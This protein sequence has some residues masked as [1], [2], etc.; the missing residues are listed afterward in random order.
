MSVKC[1]SHCAGCQRHFGGVT[2]FDKHRK[3]FQC[4][5]PKGL[6]LVERTCNLMYEWEAT[7]TNHEQVAPGVWKA[8]IYMKL[9]FD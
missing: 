7:S 5:E 1:R 9:S 4:T 8:W 3:K 2:A 6:R